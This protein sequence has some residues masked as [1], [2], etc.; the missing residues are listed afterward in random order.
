MSEFVTQQ[1]VLDALRRGDLDPDSQIILDIDGLGEPFKATSAYGT[2]EITNI[3]TLFSDDNDWAAEVQAIADASVL[4]DP[5]ETEIAYCEAG[6]FY[7]FYEMDIQDTEGF[8]PNLIL[9]S[10]GA[11]YYDDGYGLRP[12]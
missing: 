5:S 11:V 7:V 9:R 10:D 2:A 1:M 8:G 3:V 6:E 12:R 4:A